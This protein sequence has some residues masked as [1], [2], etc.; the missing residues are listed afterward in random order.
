MALFLCVF[1]RICLFAIGHVIFESLDLKIH[2]WPA[3]NSLRPT[4]RVKFGYEVLSREC[5]RREIWFCQPG[6]SNSMTANAV[7]ASPSGYL[8]AS[9]TSTQLSTCRCLPTRHAACEHTADPQTAGWVCA[10]HIFR[11]ADKPC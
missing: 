10:L 11:S 9:Q 2:F 5:H 3:G 8:Q 6:F 7:T 4:L 1:D